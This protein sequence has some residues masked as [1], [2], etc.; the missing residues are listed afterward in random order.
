MRNSILLL[1]LLISMTIIGKAQKIQLIPFAGYTFGDKFNFDQGTARIGDGFTY[2]GTLSLVDREL[3]ALELTYS[4]QNAD[5]SA[6]SE[7]HNINVNEPVSINYILLGGSKL[8]PL[9]ERFI[10]F[11]GMGMGVGIIGSKADTFS[12][13]TKFAVGANGGVKYYFNRKIGVRLQSNLNF[14]F[15]KVGGTLWWDTENNTQAGAT[16]VVPFIQFGFT[17]GLVFNLN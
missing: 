5:A 16:S 13:L 6:Y 12:T 4:R 1:V 8:W 11:A 7:Y 15:T 17:G 3:S 9:S 10:L 14:P 2:G